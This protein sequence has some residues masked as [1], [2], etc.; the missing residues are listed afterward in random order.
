M[1]EIR[2]KVVEFELEKHPN[3]DSLSI[4]KIKNTGWQQ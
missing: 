3:A 4:C 1:T 2:A